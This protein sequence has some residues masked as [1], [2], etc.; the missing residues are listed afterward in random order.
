MTG[1]KNTRRTLFFVAAVLLCLLLYQ[2]GQWYFR[3]RRETSFYRPI[4]AL[5]A[6]YEQVL[7]LG[8]TAAAREVLKNQSVQSV[9][10]VLT[11]QPLFRPQQ[12]RL[13][14]YTED[15]FQFLKTREKHYDFIIVALA[16]PK[17]ETENRAF[18]NLF[19][20]MC[21]N[22]L[23]EG[24]AFVVETISPERYPLSYRCLETTIESEGLSVQSLKLTG[25]GNETR[26]VFLISAPQGEYK[27][28]AASALEAVRKD[29]ET[30]LPPVGI[31]RLNR[32]LL[33]DYLEQEKETE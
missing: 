1:K 27:P 3:N 7:V 8:S 15:A 24:G 31:N 17:T 33:L 10:L 28:T 19:Y 11:A 4:A 23:R 25:E 5:A 2:L 26:G 6:P 30:V 21:A 12:S 14:C 16:V 18:T 29:E 9:D 20:R 32:P 13:H 22:H